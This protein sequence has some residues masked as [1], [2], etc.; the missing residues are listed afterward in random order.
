MYKRQLEYGEDRIEF[1]KDALTAED[2]VLLH[3][4]LLA[5]GGSA[6][7][8][9][10]LINIFDVKKLMISFIIE[11]G[12]LEGRKKFPAAVEINSMIRV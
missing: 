10:D 1:H 2:V 8:A 7:A 3:D 4:D 5:T 9:M 11:L 6:G 12:F